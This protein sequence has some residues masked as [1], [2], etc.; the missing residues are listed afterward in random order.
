M[1]LKIIG[2]RDELR[3]RVTGFLFSPDGTRKVNEISGSQLLMKVLQLLKLPLPKPKPVPKANRP[4]EAGKKCICGNDVASAIGIKCV[5]CGYFQHRN[6]MGKAANMPVFECP[7]CQLCQVEPYEQILEVVL[8]P[9]VT[10]T[11][12]LAYVQKDFDYGEDMNRRLM[13]SGHRRLLQIRCIRLDEE[14]FT[15]HWPIECT[16]LLNGKS[17]FTFAQPPAS[18][19]RKRKDSSLTISALGIG[20]NQAMVMRQKEEDEYAFGIF[21]VEVMSA[22]A[23]FRRMSVTNTLS[24]EAGKSFVRSRMASGSAEVT[25]KECKTPLK[26][27]LSRMLPEVPARCSTCVHLQCFDL[28]P[29][30]VLQE[31]AKTN[32]WRCPICGV[33]GL[34]VIVDKY[35]QDLMV[36]ATVEKADWAEFRADGSYKLIPEV[37]EDDDAEPVKR[38]PDRRADPHPV[39][40][41]VRALEM[42]E[43]LTWNDFWKGNSHTVIIPAEVV[44]A[45]LSYQ[46]AKMLTLQGR[47]RLL[48]L[49]P[50]PS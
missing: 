29:Y 11:L 14:G 49:L 41:A 5:R 47:T 3:L 9:A 38:E 37:D 46:R 15:Y 27:P 4:E 12:G 26:C 50:K 35:M 31:R 44:R 17:L 42:C 10:T 34:S 43:K 30:I 1:G 7:M 24:F 39:K 20:H 48:M 32:R 16:V 33:M 13:E 45:S 2:R 28:R 18:C 22:D 36:R 19:S 6:C 8:P 40:K 23:V 25:S 21:I